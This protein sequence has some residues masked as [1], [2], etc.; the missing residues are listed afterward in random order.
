M[1]EKLTMFSAQ[2]ANKIGLLCKKIGTFK[3]ES[4][5]VIKIMFIMGSDIII[6]ALCSLYVCMGNMR[7]IS[8]LF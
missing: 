8:T 1:R 5:M 6:V 3:F 4:D 7:V 2:R